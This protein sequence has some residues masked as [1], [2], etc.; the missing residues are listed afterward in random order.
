MAF[1]WTHQLTLFTERI[2]P[3]QPG[4]LCAKQD[5]IS[6]WLSP[7]CRELWGP[8]LPSGSRSFGLGTFGVPLRWQDL[9]SP[10]M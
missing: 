10:G 1:L 6:R 8:W 9:E 2:L 7:H 4:V 5:P 3:L